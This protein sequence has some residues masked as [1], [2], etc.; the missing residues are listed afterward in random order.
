MT[1]LFQAKEVT[2]TPLGSI[3]IIL[4]DGPASFHTSVTHD[5]HVIY[6]HITDPTSMEEL[7]EKISTLE[8]ELFA[9]E[10]SS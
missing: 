7:R 4:Q 3:V 1:T 8:T 10:K 9:Y 5:V 6:E 2:H